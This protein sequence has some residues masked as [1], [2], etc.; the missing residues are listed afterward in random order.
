MSLPFQH[1]RLA[2]EFERLVHQDPRFEVCAE[3]TLGL[4]CFRL[5]V[6][7]SVLVFV[8]C[9]SDGG[10]RIVHHFRLQTS[11]L[12]PRE[13][14]EVS[15]LLPVWGS[16]LPAL[17]QSDGS[18]GPWAPSSRSRPPLLSQTKTSHLCRPLA[19]ES[20]PLSPLISAA[21]MLGH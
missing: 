21:A 2:H 18:G 20:S 16:R 6:C 7:V 11:M 3:V 5:K 9:D 12:A 10:E 15:M 19:L 17:T 13:T 8:L 14:T 1:V 4:V